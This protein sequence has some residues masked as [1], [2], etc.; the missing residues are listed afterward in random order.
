MRPALHEAEAEAR[1]YEAKAVVK[2][3][4]LEAMLASRT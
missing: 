3:F 4:G 1:Y 2:K